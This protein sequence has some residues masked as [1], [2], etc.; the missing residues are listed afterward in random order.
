[1][2][3]ILYLDADSLNKSIFNIL[4]T[5][6]FDKIDV[7][8]LSS[9][10]SGEDALRNNSYD[11]LVSQI[12]PEKM[13]DG[14]NIIKNLRLGFYGNTNRSI[15][16]IAY[17]TIN[18]T[19]TSQ[20]CLEAGFNAFVPMP[21]TEHRLLIEIQRLLN[22]NIIDESDDA[23]GEKVFC[24]NLESSNVDKD[25]IKHLLKKEYGKKIFLFQATSF[26]AAEEVIKKTIIDFVICDGPGAASFVKNLRDGIYGHNKKNM[27]AIICT[28]YAN[29]GDKEEFMKIGFSAYIAK[30][31]NRQEFIK[32]VNNHVPSLK[33]MSF[34]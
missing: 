21:D 14:L 11:L 17:T 19:S 1:M 30:P 2:K 5:G 28:G 9:T 34:N 6:N 10:L 29:I 16:A 12:Y 8:A 24:L 3:K 13:I 26:S 20:E 15:P 31:I 32:T 22:I 23:T 4:V 25:L 18:L 33:I 27:T 7:T